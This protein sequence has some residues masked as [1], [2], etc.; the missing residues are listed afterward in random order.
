MNCVA[1]I[2]FITEHRVWNNINSPIIEKE[3]HVTRSTLQ[4]THNCFIY[5]KWNTTHQ[6]CW[7]ECA[8][9]H[10]SAKSVSQ[11]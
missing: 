8:L 7:R 1:R 3:M 9:L 10:C 11:C 2:V 5:D 6:W 4:F